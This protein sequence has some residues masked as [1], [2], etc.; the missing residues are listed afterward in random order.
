MANAILNFHF[1]FLTPSLTD[2]LKSRGASAS[3]KHFINDLSQSNGPPPP[4]KGSFSL[5]IDVGKMQRPAITISVRTTAHPECSPCFTAFTEQVEKTFPDSTFY[6]VKQKHFSAPGMT[7][8]RKQPFHLFCQN[9][10]NPLHV[11]WETIP[12]FTAKS[13]SFFIFKL[14]R[15]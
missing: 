12:L 15:L 3:K 6:P 4:W 10:R 11:I 8:L 7:L 13:C 9:Y 14:N 2:N 5:E 1:D